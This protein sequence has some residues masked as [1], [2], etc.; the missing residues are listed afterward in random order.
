MFES[1]TVEDTTPNTDNTDRKRVSKACIE[2][3]KKHSRCGVERPCER[4][5]RLGLEC[6]DV[7]KKEKKTE[8]TKPLV[9]VEYKQN[10][11]GKKRKHSGDDIE[12]QTFF[13]EKYNNFT[14]DMN[15]GSEFYNSGYSSQEFND[16]TFHDLLDQDSF[17]SCLN[18]MEC[19]IKDRKEVVKFGSKETLSLETHTPGRIVI[20]DKNGN[21]FEM[22]KECVRIYQ[23]ENPDELEAIVF[24]V[25]WV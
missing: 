9:F 19:E 17:Q 20:K 1:K 7:Q 6:I 21:I 12:D 25:F 14:I 16:M 4:C 15:I 5:Q 22:V 2:C 11:D 23:K 18:R 8:E 13:Q 24:H 3:K 10:K